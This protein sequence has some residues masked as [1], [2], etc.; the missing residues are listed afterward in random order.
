MDATPKQS[1]ICYYCTF[2][3]PIKVAQSCKE[4]ICHSSGRDVVCETS[5]CSKWRLDDRWRPRPIPSQPAGLLSFLGHSFH[6]CVLPLAAQFTC[7]CS[8]KPNLKKSLRK[9]LKSRH[10]GSRVNPVC[11]FEKMCSSVIYRVCDLCCVAA[12][13]PI[14]SVWVVTGKIMK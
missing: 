7:N 9:H 10:S 4:S 14:F 3:F 1:L 2:L 13:D 6:S 5:K 8:I 12:F 11:I